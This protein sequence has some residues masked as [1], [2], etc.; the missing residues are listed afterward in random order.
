MGIRNWL[1]GKKGR[2]PEI[3]GRSEGGS[4]LL[5]YSSENSGAPEMGFADP[6]TAIDPGERERIYEQIFGTIDSVHHELIPFVPHIDVYQFA[7]TEQRPF[8]TY[9]T[10]GMS[11]LAMNSP[12]EL[13]PGFRRIELVLYAS[14]DKPDFV[15]VL[16]Q[17]A[18][19]PHDHRTWIHWGH[20]MPNGTPPAPLF[21]TRQLDCMFFMPSIVT[22]D[23]TLEERLSW[24]DQPVKLVW[25]VPIT[26][27]ECNLKLERGSDAIYDLFDQHQHPFIFTGDRSSYV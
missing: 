22:P 18:H 26:T 6:S 12:A 14:E 27:A 15:Q 19:F 9:V 16:R 8:I 13:G 21:G 4:R 24:R 2:G 17:L 10:G 3:V 5:K 23:S 11:D 20:T 1:F 25:C 7:P